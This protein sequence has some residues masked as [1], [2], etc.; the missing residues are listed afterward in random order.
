MYAEML[1]LGRGLGVKISAL[2]HGRA[3]TDE[4]G[5][6]HSAL[7]T[8]CSRSWSPQCGGSY[9]LSAAWRQMP[10]ICGAL[11]LAPTMIFDQVQPDEA[12]QQL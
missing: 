6:A 1:T 10:G 5:A 2:F 8:A 12:T 9:N 11:L 3:M 4:N 7:P